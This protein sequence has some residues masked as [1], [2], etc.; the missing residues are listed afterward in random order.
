[1]RAQNLELP[2]EFLRN[3]RSA[4]AQE[5]QR[6]EALG[7]PAISERQSQ[8]RDMIYAAVGRVLPPALRLHTPEV[9]KL[10][11]QIDHEIYNGPEPQ[12]DAPE[13]PELVLQD[14]GRLR[15]KVGVLAVK[16]DGGVAA[17]LRAFQA[18]VVEA[19]LKQT[20][21]AADAR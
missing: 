11:D 18:L 14:S 9:K 1:Q 8:W 10:F 13:L 16:Q 19:M 7:E 6:V 20:Y 21:F 5:R 12:E 17:D 2:E 4:F 3:P 15:T